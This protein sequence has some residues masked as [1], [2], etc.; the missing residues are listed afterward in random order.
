MRESVK[1]ILLL[2][3]MVASIVVGCL[4]LTPIIPSEYSK[5]IGLMC[6]IFGVIS[7]IAQAAV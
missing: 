6:A 5:G 1:R 4:C 3:V 2:V 7:L